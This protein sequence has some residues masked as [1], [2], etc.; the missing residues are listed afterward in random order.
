MIGEAIS[1]Y[2]MVENP[3]AG[4]VY[5]VLLRT[6]TWVTTQPLCPPRETQR[7]PLQ[8]AALAK[9]RTTYSRGYC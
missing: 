1:H 7:S 2:R 8:E 6:S 9:A 3:A 5:S 4:C